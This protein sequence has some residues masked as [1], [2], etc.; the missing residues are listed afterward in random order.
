MRHSSSILL[1]AIF[2]VT[3][4][5]FKPLC[6]FCQDEP[7][8]AGKTVNIWVSNLNY[9]NPK[10]TR[11]Q[12]QEALRQIGTNSLPFL[13]AEMHTL[14]ELCAKDT[15]NGYT[16][17]L[18]D[19]IVNVRAAFKVLGSTAKPAISELINLLNEGK[20]SGAA[21]YV[22]TQVDP[23]AAVVALTQALTNENYEV[24]CYAAD[25][26]F[27]VRSNADIAIAVTN[28]VLCLKMESLGDLTLTAGALE[29]DTTRLRSSAAG[30]LGAIGKNPE[31]V[32]PALIERLQQ[33]KSTIVRVRAAQ[34]LGEL[35][36]SA[37]AAIP[38]LTQAAQDVDRHI[39][40]E[41]TSAL[42]KIQSSS[43]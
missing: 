15:T 42:K 11:N 36:K 43:P 23:K 9:K 3:G 17:D 8:Y 5:V 24:R 26:L 2:F 37:Q 7:S 28:L 29:T 30:T 39:S 14:G 38:A 4:A 33:D 10:E 27:L 18:E 35:G 16:S 12:A 6:A 25:N 32:V 13:L 19:R 1:F 21:A 41:A 31:I 20:F 22:L 40:L 34:A